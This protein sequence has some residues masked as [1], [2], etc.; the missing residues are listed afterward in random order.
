MVMTAV[1][2]AA[3]CCGS[4]AAATPR[5][6]SLVAGSVLPPTCGT[7][8]ERHL[9]GMDAF[10]LCAFAGAR[11]GTVDATLRTRNRKD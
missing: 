4:A 5:G 2:S 9:V 1:V 8:D 10:A 6:A 3:T 11:G 7:L